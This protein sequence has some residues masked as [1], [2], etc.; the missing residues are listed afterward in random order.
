VRQVGLARAAKDPAA[1]ERARALW[2]EAWAASS[3]DADIRQFPSG[4]SQLPVG[5]VSFR[6]AE[7]YCAWRAAELGVPVRLPTEA[8]W[9]Q[10]AGGDDG[11]PYPWGAT[12]DPNRVTF[13]RLSEGPVPV[14]AELQGQSPFDLRHMAG[15][16]A[17]WVDTVWDDPQE[18]RDPSS[19]V[20]KGGSFR[21][22]NPENL[23]L[24]ARLRGGVTE[25]KPEWGF[26][27]V[28]E[29]GE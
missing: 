12:F 8:E 18:G 3:R 16:V 27:V 6:D 25:R 2:P 5:G 9:L 17:E 15:N 22:M 26:R 21:S 29:A 24:D 10:A 20:L 1:L 19:R 28:V 13:R 11:R 23:R 14:T 4:T 7:Q